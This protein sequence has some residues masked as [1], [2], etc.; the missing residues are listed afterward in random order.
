MKK[1]IEREWQ[2]H[3]VLFQN[4]NFYKIQVFFTK[5]YIKFKY[6]AVVLDSKLPWKVQ[7]KEE[8]E[9]T[10]ALIMQEDSGEVI[11]KMVRLTQYKNTR[12]RLVFKVAEMLRLINN[13]GFDDR[14]W[15]NVINEIQAIKG[16]YVG[17]DVE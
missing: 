8:V 1:I 9:A 12:R 6:L 11:K 13:F 10:T 15:A 2:F 7:E 14:K 17:K 3:T 5:T 4:K 16:T